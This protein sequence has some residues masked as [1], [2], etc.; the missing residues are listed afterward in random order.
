MNCIDNGRSIPHHP[1]D[2]TPLPG[3][4]K[5]IIREWAEGMRDW[6]WN[7][8]NT[9]EY[10]AAVVTLE[11]PGTSVMTRLAGLMKLCKGSCNPAVAKAE[12]EALS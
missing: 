5:L 2:H 12:L 11:N 1:L 7:T 6:R 3:N 4:A 9:P 10:Y 8:W